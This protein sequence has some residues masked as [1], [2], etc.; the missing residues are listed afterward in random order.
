[1]KSKAGVAA[2]K[3]LALLIS[4]RGSNMLNVLNH[5]TQAGG[6]L[7]GAATV[8]VVVSNKPQAPGLG[9]ARQRGVPALCVPSAHREREAFESDLISILG[10]FQ[11]DFI[12]CAGFMR[13]L[14]PLFIDAFRGR[15]VNIHPAD[16]LAYQGPHGYKWAFEKQLAETFVT[17][18][19][20]DRGVD[21]GEV[22]A[23]AAVDL[24]GA[25]TLEEIERRG[26][27]VEHQLFPEALSRI[28]EA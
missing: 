13:V 19:W 23:R 6:R 2:V 25:T 12:V 9:A 8:C 4:G 28:C 22:I 26:L 5:T 15:I 16:T 17:V 14:T 10:D 21:T 24:R 18:H 20:V 7:Y 27:L 3:R 11:P 1:M